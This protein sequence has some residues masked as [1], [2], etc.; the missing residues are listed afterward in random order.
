MEQKQEDRKRRKTK[1]DATECKRTRIKR[2]QAESTDRRDRSTRIFKG[3]EYTDG[4]I[5][6][7]GEEY[8]S[9]GEGWGSTYRE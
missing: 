5:L 9:M 3:N 4:G 8:E 7:E 2:I 6:R 1:R